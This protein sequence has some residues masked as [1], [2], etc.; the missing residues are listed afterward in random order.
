MGGGELQDGAIRLHV[1]I[2]S[3]N[4]SNRAYRLSPPGPEGQLGGRSRLATNGGKLVGR[5]ID[6]RVEIWLTRDNGTQVLTMWPGEYRARLEPLE[7]LDERGQVIAG[8]GD[9]IRV[10]GGFLPAKIASEQ[11]F[12]ASRIID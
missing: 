10:V 4:A 2:D 1:D 11:V 9:Q 7:L 6:G 8:E 5:V 12:F 3:A